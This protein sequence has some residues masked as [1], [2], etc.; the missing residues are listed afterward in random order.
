MPEIF[1][2]LSGLVAGV[3]AWLPCTVGLAAHRY[4]LG[5]AQIRSKNRW[6]LLGTRSPGRFSASGRIVFVLVMCIWLC[7]F[8]GAMA[9]PFLAANA[10]GVPEESPSIGYAINANMLVAV[11]SFFAGRSIWRRLAL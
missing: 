4:K 3:I 5:G 10:L 2:V 8:F 9:L 7:I 11:V 6:V 1:V